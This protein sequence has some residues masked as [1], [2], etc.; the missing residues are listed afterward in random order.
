MEWAQGKP[1]PVRNQANAVEPRI[2]GKIE[3]GSS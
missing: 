2:T 3:H 1:V